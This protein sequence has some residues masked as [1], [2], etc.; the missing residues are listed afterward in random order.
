MYISHPSA[1]LTETLFYLN[2]R[3]GKIYVDC[4]LGGSGH[5]AA[6]CQKMG[7]EGRLIGLDQ[8]RDA[9]MHAKEILKPFEKNIDLF[10][11]NYTDLGG[12]LAS[13]NIS[14]VDGILMD[15]GLS[16]HQLAGSG[17]GFSFKNPEPLD[18]RMDIRSGTTAR[19]IIETRDA[20][21]MADLFFK[22][23]EERYSRSIARHIVEKRRQ[24]PIETSKQLADIVCEA[25]PAKGR[26]QHIHPAT[27]VFMALRIAVN[28]ELERLVEFLDRVPDLLNSGGRLC[29]LSFHSLEDRIVKQRI[30]DLEGACV[31]PPDFPVC[32][33][34]RTPVMRVITRKP[35]RPSAAEID[36]NPLAR[37]TRLRA[38]E[39][40]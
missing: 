2:I 37:S 39:K 10:H 21:E 6:I 29:V 5:A 38:A 14:G 34:H 23:G 18:M 13:L 28:Q 27:R 17:R 22:L 8:D 19:S 1:L 30:R 31:C 36:R 33:C 24:Q 32:S 12:V 35:V 4:T 15:L 16:L 25:I 26:S 40:L 3:P 20:S 7:Q 9:I 11:C